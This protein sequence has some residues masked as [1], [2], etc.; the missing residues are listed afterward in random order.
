MFIV[1]GFISNATDR[2]RERCRSFEGIVEGGVL[3]GG[4]VLV[5]RSARDA[6]VYYSNKAT[7]GMDGICIRDTEIKHVTKPYTDI[8]TEQNQ[9]KPSRS[10]L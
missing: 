3:G 9:T 10:L 6:F 1:S 4:C 7:L 2:S 5:I 8:R